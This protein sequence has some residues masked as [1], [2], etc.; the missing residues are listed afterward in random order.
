MTLKDKQLKA[1]VRKIQKEAGTLPSLN[2]KNTY[3]D[4][5]IVRSQDP[6]DDSTFREMKKLPYSE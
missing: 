2:K 6:E 1:L 4:D 5:T 3:K